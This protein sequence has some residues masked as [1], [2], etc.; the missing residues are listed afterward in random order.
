VDEFLEDRVSLV[1]ATFGLGSVWISMC[2]CSLKVSLFHNLHPAR[3]LSRS[4][5]ERFQK[6]AGHGKAVNE[7]GV[8]AE[9]W[10]Y[11]AI[12]PL[13]HFPAFASPHYRVKLD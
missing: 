9:R 3:G 11:G 13:L 10:Y 7:C 4:N 6:R 2:Y 8:I 12:Y 5:K 1:S